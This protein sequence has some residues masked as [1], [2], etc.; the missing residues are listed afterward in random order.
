M[1]HLKKISILILAL[2]AALLL[3]W[4]Q[5]AATTRTLAVGSASGAKDATVSVP[6]TLD[7][8]S[9]IGGVAFTLTFDP[10]VL[11]FKGLEQAGTAPVLTDGSNTS[12]TA[13]ELGSDLFYQANA[14]TAGRVFVA[15]A[16]ANAIS[17]GNLFNAKFKIL[18][19]DGMYPIVIQSTIVKNEDAGYSVP[20]SIPV[21]VGT[22]TFNGTVYNQTDFTPYYAGTG[23]TLV[24][25]GITVNATK[26]AI[27]GKAYYGS[28]TGSYATGCTVTLMRNSTYGYVFDSSTTVNSSGDF[29]FSK[30]VG[31]YQI[32]VTS[33]DPG[34]YSSQTNS[35]NVTTAN[36]S[37]GN[38]V[39]PTPMRL[40]GSVTVNG[41]APPAGLRIKVKNGSTV[42]GIYTVNSD[43]SFQTPA[44]PS[45]TY[46]IYAVY[47][48][49]EK[50]LTD[51]KWDEL[52]LRTISGT[53]SNLTG[54]A[55]VTAS[56]ATGKMYK[57]ITVSANGSYSITNLVNANDY[58]VSI[59]GNTFPVTYYNGTQD[60]TAATPVNLTTANFTNANFDCAGTGYITKTISG[61]VTENSTAVIGIGV[62]AFKT[63]TFGLT[64]ATT[65]G[66]GGYSI[67]VPV[68]TYEIFVIKANGKIFYYK[69]GGT[70]TQI[71]AQVTKLSVTTTG[72]YNGKNMNITEGSY[73][74]TGKVT[75]K[76][77]DG[78]PAA[79]VLVMARGTAGGA[80]ALTG[81]DGAYTL[82]G[83]NAGTYLVEMNPLNGKFAIQ[84]A[85]VTVPDT[86][87]QDF[88]IDSG[89]TLSGKVHEEGNT[90]ATIQDALLYLR[91]Q[92]TGMLVNGKVY[93]SDNAGNY[94][95][96]D[97]P[98]SVAT[99][100]A[101]HPDYAS[102]QIPD[103]DIMADMTQNVPMS[104]G[105]YFIVT[106]TD[107]TSP[108]EGALVIVSRSEGIPVYGMTDSN[109]TCRIYGLNA[110]YSDYTIM[111]QKSGYVR[112][113]VTAQTPAVA[114]ATVPTFTLLQPA[115][116]FSLSG[117]ITNGCGGS[118]P[119]VGARVMVSTK[120]TGFF[121]ST[122]TDSSGNY[123]FTGLPQATD[124]SFMV[125]I[126]N[127]TWVDSMPLNLNS[128]TDKD[129]NIPCF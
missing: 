30:P 75:Y 123:S 116:F 54:S 102:T 79:N 12:Y 5:A 107:G 34:Y 122:V 72:T 73:S 4:G 94:T 8:T 89:N 60:Y 38:I 106:V 32:F 118:A 104:K 81:S 111:V 24:A 117:T 35:F 27:S 86:T 113:T 87:V 56:S 65:D 42:V 20:A 51:G 46:T 57:T 70:A 109:G 108:I 120:I 93:F 10:A 126:G 128:N 90:T 18:G 83:L 68:G 66:S 47:G 74:L 31:N 26:Y 129:A 99:L 49:Q 103:L 95:I 64:R 1:S 13:N 41:N 43:G 59:A 15:A 11:E 39:L 2:F 40:S 28:T 78:D 69:D 112:Q 105:A 98:N 16:S 110:S 88:V 84:S 92:E 7:N 63:D 114:G 62:Y 55:I 29:S 97:I 22:S 115:A 48:N 67:T 125:L 76:R 121:A 19:G 9:A 25:G 124:Y 45:A 96:A 33:N 61:T 100:N 44:L 23:V 17:S 71:E 85:S 50:L 6:I 53:I 91:N 119:A 36:Y 80:I 52:V 3:S 37:V 127:N 82:S 101:S 14:D 77:A 58:I 21:L